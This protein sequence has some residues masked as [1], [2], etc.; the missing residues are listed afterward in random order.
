MPTDCSTDL[1]AFAPVESRRVE[2]LS[3]AGLATSDASALL[4]GATRLC[5][6]HCP[7]LCPNCKRSGCRRL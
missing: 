3:D 4:L 1:F 5:D 6:S 2:A 7:I